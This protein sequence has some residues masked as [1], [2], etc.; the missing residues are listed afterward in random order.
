MRFAVVAVLVL[1]LQTSVS[2]Q[3]ERPPQTPLADTVAEL[4]KQ[5]R[6][7]L[8]QGV[9]SNDPA[10]GS[11][12]SEAYA[13]LFKKSGQAG[14]RQLQSSSIDSIA[15]QAAWQEVALTVPEGE[16]AQTERPDRQKLSWFLGFLEGRTRCHAPSLW[17]NRVLDM[18]AKRRDLI[19]V[20]YPRNSDD[21]L[22]HNAGLDD[23]HTPRDS[24]L[25]RQGG[26]VILRIGDDEASIPEGILEKSVDGRVRGTVTG[27]IHRDHCYVAVPGGFGH[28]FELRCLD[29]ETGSEVWKANVWG[30]YWGTVAAE[31][32]P[33]WISV[34]EQ[35]GRVVVFGA[36][37]AG[38]F[39][40]A[41]AMKDGENLFR[42]SSRY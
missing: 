31:F 1:S 42:F 15:L 35:N 7:A 4:E 17:A 13:A 22:Y 3:L 18:R 9:S 20:V 39:V 26:R 30:T 25:K 8:S 33:T 24:T 2:A 10:S 19:Y 21:F 5:I 12:A 11:S 38:I 28:P 37:P 6:D 27:L 14:I 40:E 32:R 16:P 23:A 34:T 36:A 29:R 41:F